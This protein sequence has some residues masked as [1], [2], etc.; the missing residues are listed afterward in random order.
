MALSFGGLLV[1]NLI[2]FIK[3]GYWA[4]KELGWNPVYEMRPLTLQF[5]T[6]AAQPI[7]YIPDQLRGD[8]AFLMKLLENSNASLQKMMDVGKVLNEVQYGR[9]L[10]NFHQ[11]RGGEN[12]DNVWWESSL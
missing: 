8:L 5:D 4:L 2:F 9:Q 3:A 7:G 1:V 11:Q 6:F 10:E 12:N